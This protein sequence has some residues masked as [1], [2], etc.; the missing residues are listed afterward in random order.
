LGAAFMA[1][2]AVGYWDSKETI[3][4]LWQESRRFDPQ[5][6]A[7]DRERKMARWRRS[8]ERTRDYERPE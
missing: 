6:D 3:A 8:V 1:G 5:T 7:E 4:S 2:L